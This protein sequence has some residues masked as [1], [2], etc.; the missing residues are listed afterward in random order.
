MATTDD[1]LDDAELAKSYIT[2]SNMSDDSKKAYLKL[3]NIT[4]M[5]TNGISP[6]EKIQMMTEAI[7]LL[8]VTQGMFMS[9]IDERIDKAIERSNEEKCS[10]CKAMKYTNAMEQKEREQKIIEKYK[11]QMGIKNNSIENRSWSE[12]LKVML[13]KP[14][15]Y[16]FG[17]IV[18]FSPYSVEIIKQVFAFCSK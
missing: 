18:C 2:N 6:E 1:I 16:I 17:C 14:Y 12:V 13:T 8:A 10:N 11:Q 7:Q 9:T 5:A 4:T 3:I 15:I